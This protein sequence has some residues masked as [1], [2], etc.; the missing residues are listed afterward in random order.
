MPGSADLCFLTDENV[1]KVLK[2]FQ[3]ARVQVSSPDHRPGGR[4]S[5]LTGLG[6][7]QGG[8][9]NR[10]GGEDPQCICEGSRWQSD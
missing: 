7:R 4:F 9:K 6:R 8:R 5:P 10:S 3:E 1:E 2:V